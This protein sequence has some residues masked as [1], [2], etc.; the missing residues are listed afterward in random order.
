MG[1]NDPK[2]E[3]HIKNGNIYIDNPDKGVIIK[4]LNGYCYIL[5]VVNGVVEAKTVACPN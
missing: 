2:T 5:R 1:T 3:V 4:D